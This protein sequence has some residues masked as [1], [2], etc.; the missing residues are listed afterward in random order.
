MDQIGADAQ[1]AMGSTDWLGC[2]RTHVTGTQVPA[3]LLG[4]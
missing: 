2:W 4:G 3:G 1:V